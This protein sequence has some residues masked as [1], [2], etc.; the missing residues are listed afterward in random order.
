MAN[1]YLTL[2]D[3]ARRVDPHGKIDIIAELLS[4]CNEIFDDMLWREANSPTSHKATIRTGLPQGTWR[5]MYQGV[6][7]T[8]STTAQ[9]VETMGELSAYSRI[10]RTIAELEGDVAALRMSEDNA[11][12]EG[13]SQQMA[14]QLFYGNSWTQPERFT[15]LSPRY[16]TVSTA[17]AQNAVNVLDGGGTAS[18]NS[19]MWIISW[20]ERTCHGLFPKGSKA[21]LIFEDKGD[22]RPGRDASGN[23]F[24]AFT[25]YFRWQ[26]GIS[27]PDWRYNVRVANLDS[28]T[29]AGGLASSTPPDLFAL[30]SKA[31]IRIPTMPRN[32]TGITKTDAPN[33]VAPAMRSA[34][35]VNRTVRQYMDLQAIRD[36]NVLLT[37]KEYAG[38]PVVEFRGLPIKVCDALL[39]NE[40]RVV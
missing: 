22:I 31:V 17:T 8:K 24:E 37:P 5:R 13:L 7:F 2:A 10:D 29:A 23:E 33:E 26:S 25:S 12:L 1:F 14:T 15:G 28:T 32:V 9:I 34:I 19:S 36:K 40:S 39:S 18:A 30:L 27:V 3:W 35:Y 20:G 21:G 4:Q 16:N 6:Q 11:H 38:A